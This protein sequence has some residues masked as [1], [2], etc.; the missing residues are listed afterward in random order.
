MPI[1]RASTRQI[2]DTNPASLAGEFE[3]TSKVEKFELSDA[4][5]KERRDTVLAFKKRNKLGRFNEERMARLET[6]QDQ[7]DVAEAEAVAAMHTGDR[8][9]V[10]TKEADFPRRGT[11]MFIGKG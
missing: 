10:R 3:D 4:A 6:D 8:C 2:I 5:Y 9:E 11:I 1:L 7:K